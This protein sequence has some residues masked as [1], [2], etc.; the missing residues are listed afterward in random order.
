MQA[1]GGTGRS[2][3]LWAG[4]AVLFWA[5]GFYGIAD[6][7]ALAGGRGQ[8]AAVAGLQASWGVLFTFIVSGA[9]LS[10]AARPLNPWPAL[11][12]LWTVAAALLLA[13][14]LTASADPLV[15]ALILV[16]MTAATFFAGGGRP[17]P[18]RRKLEADGVLFLLALTGAPA[19]WGYAAAAVDRSLTAGAEDDYSWGL[20]HWP[21]QAALGL[22]MA[23]IVLVMA[24]WPPGRPLQ[25]SVCCASS[26]VLGAGWLLY[27]GSAGSVDSTAMSV[28][29]ML[30][31]TAVFFC[32]FRGTGRG[33][34]AGRPAAA[35][36]PVP[37]GLRAARSVRGPGISR[38]VA[39]ASGR[40]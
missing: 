18:P 25:G 26:L 14:A 20:A 6:L 21:L 7:L 24:F 28:L 10:I 29:A 2:R 4:A 11:V 13:A 3:S 39:R 8:M 33:E 30:W 1:G 16:P 31:G 5:V 23:L 22:F 17:A 27:P 40:G 19:W 15:V 36:G 9:F 12:Q 38:P 34:P 35:G 32:R 37:P